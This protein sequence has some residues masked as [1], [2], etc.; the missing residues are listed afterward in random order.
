LA[1][2]S[3]DG[4][5]K[6]R[7]PGKL[8]GVSFMTPIRRCFRVSVRRAMASIPFGRLIEASVAALGDATAPIHRHAAPP[9]A[10]EN[11]KATVMNGGPG[12]AARSMVEAARPLTMVF[13]G[14]RFDPQSAA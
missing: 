12:A 10:A 5:P 8:I 4:K 14:K 11:L 6:A 1:G 13:R 7:R 9:S 3:Q 2:D